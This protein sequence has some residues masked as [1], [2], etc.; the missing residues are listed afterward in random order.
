MNSNLIE[1]EMKMK[2]V[3]LKY[4]VKN[5]ILFIFQ[6]ITDSRVRLHV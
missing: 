1:K 4:I 5:G 3:F 2:S 6:G